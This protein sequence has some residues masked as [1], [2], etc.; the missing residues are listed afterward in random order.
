MISNYIAPNIPKISS[1]KRVVAIL[2]SELNLQKAVEY[3]YGQFPPDQL[4]Y[5]SLIGPVAR[6]SDA[7]ARFDQML[8]NMQNSEILLAPLRNQEA[9]ISS[10]MEGM[11]CTMDEILRFEAD[12][13]AG[14]EN[15]PYVRQEVIETVLYRR[16]LSKAVEA[17]DGGIPI[18]LWL[19]RG[20]HSRLLSSG[21]GASSSPGKYKSEQNYL[22]DKNKKHVLFIPISPDRLDV[23]IEK[24][25]EY[26]DN[27]SHQV[28]IKTAVSHLEFQALHPFEDG[29]GRIGRMIIT[30]FLWTSGVISSPHFYLSEYLEEHKDLYVKSMR[31]VSE[32]GEWTPW[33][34]FFLNALESQ[35]IRQLELAENIRDLYE[36]M[37][38]KFSDVL[39]S[40]WSINTLDFIFTNPYFR[41]NTFTNS[42]GIP[43]SSAARFTRLLLDKGLL[44]TLEEP[45]GRRPALYMFEPLVQLVR[46]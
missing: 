10:R 46:A 5:A 34:V 12:N 1:I 35:A 8:K 41:N 19:I 36:D 11:F 26:F 22:F 9:V 21:R 42:S 33:C 39:A 32:N 44:V 30:L 18:S 6:A 23:G 15:I 25:F 40:K 13:A 27:N 28:L 24:L 43:S 16:A 17:I 45:S 14:V 4:D 7:I 37:K 31:D 3:H 29:N 38:L 2:R 20:L